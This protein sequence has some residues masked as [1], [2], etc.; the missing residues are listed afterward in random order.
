MK[1]QQ[2]LTALGLDSGTLA[3]FTGTEKHYRIS[4]RH[5]LTDGT[6]HLAE[7]GACFWMMDAVASHLCEIGTGDW[8]VLVRVSVTQGR[9][10]M[11]YEDG[12]GL[13]HAR[14]EI[15]CGQKIRN[16]CAQCSTRATTVQGRALG[17]CRP[18]AAVAC[19][20]LRWIGDSG[21]Q[22]GGFDLGFGSDGY[23]D[24]TGRSAWR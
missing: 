18:G 13:E 8:F 15:P 6:K 17:S 24:H 14:Q 20:C 12:N 2:E 5:L 11:V 21:R 3:Q 10:V 16:T 1:T 22:R 4:R 7:Q 23:F 9:A 19:G